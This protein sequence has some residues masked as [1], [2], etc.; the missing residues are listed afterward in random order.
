MSQSPTPSDSHCDPQQN[1]NLGVFHH[2][3]PDKEQSTLHIW[4]LSTPPRPRWLNLHTPDLPMTQ[5]TQQPRLPR[6]T[7]DF[8]PLRPHSHRPLQNSPRLPDRLSALNAISSGFPESVFFRSP[9]LEVTP[10][11]RGS[12]HILLLPPPMIQPYRKLILKSF[13]H[14]SLSTHPGS[15]WRT[16]ETQQ[17]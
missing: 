11:S 7:L 5:Q 14:L 12:F 13:S 3:G 9:Q 6:Y 4:P 15:S 10:L 1:S 16:T 8:L 17:M 2:K